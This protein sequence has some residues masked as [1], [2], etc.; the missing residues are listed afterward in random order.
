MTLEQSRYNA[1]HRG[2]TKEV[3]RLDRLMA[4]LAEQRHAYG[5][6]QR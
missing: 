6:G 5:R 3:A 4:R 1:Q 2:D